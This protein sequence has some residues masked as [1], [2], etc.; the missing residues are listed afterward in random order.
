MTPNLNGPPTILLIQGA[1]APSIW[2][3]QPIEIGTLQQYLDVPQFKWAPY[4]NIDPGSPGTFNLMPANQFKRITRVKV[5]V[6]I[7]KVAQWGP[8]LTFLWT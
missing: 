2:F 3:F 1:Q 8:H 6:F 5:R 4:N 7:V